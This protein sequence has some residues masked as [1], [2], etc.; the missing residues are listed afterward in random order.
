MGK[1]SGAGA[2][3]PTPGRCGRVHLC[4]RLPGHQRHP[5]C[6]RWAPRW[7]LPFMQALPALGRP[8]GLQPRPGSP[9]CG[10]PGSPCTQC[11]FTSTSTA[12][13]VKFL[14]ELQAQEV[15]EGST[16]CLRCELSR[17]G[18][19]VEWRKGSLQLF[20]CAKYKMVQKGMTVELLVLGAEQE[21]AG[22]YTCDTGHAQST[23]SLVVRGEL[24]TGPSAPMQQGMPC[25]IPLSAPLPSPQPL[26]PCSRPSCRT[27]NR[28]QAVWPSCAAN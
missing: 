17:E 23:A 28:R 2:S 21:D 11:P 12:A 18:A 22:H 8:S 1:H 16:A 10:V 24:P 25:I 5:Y 27:W 13:P 9:I 4:L 3:G 20:P 26:G 6:H 15:D 7:A 14:R 19:S